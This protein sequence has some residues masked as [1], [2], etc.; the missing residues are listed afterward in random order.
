MFVAVTM[1]F[2]LYAAAIETDELGALADTFGALLDGR[3]FSKR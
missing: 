2:S 1:G 3:L